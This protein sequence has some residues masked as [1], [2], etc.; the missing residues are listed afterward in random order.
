MNGGGA[1]TLARLRQFYYWPRMTDAYIFIALDHLTRYVWLR[2]IPKA[3]VLATVKILK[4]DIFLQFGV[5]EAIHTDNGKTAN[6]SLQVIASERVN[7]SLKHE[8]LLSQGVDGV[9]HLLRG[10]QDFHLP[11][12]LLSSVEIVIN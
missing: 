7:Q 4:N 11:I 1:K 10:T 12:P 5:P 9:L 8:T 6:Y 3:T 2:A